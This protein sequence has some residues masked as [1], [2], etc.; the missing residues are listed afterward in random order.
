MIAMSDVGTALRLAVSAVVSWSLPQAWWPAMAR[1]LSRLGGILS[2]KTTAP[3]AARVARAFGGDVAIAERVA[4]ELRGGR[5]EVAFQCLRGYR[6]GGWWPKVAV[7]GR[8]HID[9]ALASG[10]GCV[11]WIAHFVFAPNI[12]K[13]GLDR[14]GY[15]VSHL[16]RPDHGFSSTRF[17]IRCLNPVRTR[18]ED[19]HLAERIRFDRAHPARALIRARN[20]VA[21]S[22]VVS[23]TAGAWEGSAVVEA[24]FLGS[25]IALALG[26]VW[27]ARTSGAALLPVFAM[28]TQRPD[29]FLV[30]IG[31]PIDTNADAS[32]EQALAHATEQFLLAHET[33]LTRY[34]AQ[35]RG[36]S[37]LRDSRAAFGK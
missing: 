25:R 9:V 24:D 14:L 21:G 32:E 11:L 35:W 36:W 37:A 6:P 12:A 28:R 3:V 23:F 7:E 20:I 10:K 13:M 33:R 4:A 34:P 18:F 8:E 2:G 26:P 17:G 19:S 29:T 16:S 22:G 1:G 15:R 5:Y 31:S 30:E 27:L